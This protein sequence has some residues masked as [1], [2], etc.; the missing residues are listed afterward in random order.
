[1]KCENK[2]TPK[3]IILNIKVRDKMFDKLVIKIKYSIDFNRN[4][5][6]TKL[7]NKEQ[8]PCTLKKFVCPESFQKDNSNKSWRISE[9][10]AQF[11]ISIIILTTYANISKKC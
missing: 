5:Y 2:T 8:S 7:C 9:S 10:L 11:V 6:E 3:T 1:M 4:I